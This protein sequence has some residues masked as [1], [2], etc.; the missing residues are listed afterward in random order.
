MPKTKNPF[1]S[2]DE[3]LIALDFYLKYGNKMPDQS[4]IEIQELSNWLNNLQK[5][6]GGDLPDKFRNINGVYMKLMNFRRI[7]PSYHGVGL[8]NG[9]KD[10]KVVWD[11][12]AANSG[13]LNKI[14]T[15]IKSI[16]KNEKNL[17]QLPVLLENE[18]EGNEG[19]V[20]SRVHRFRERNPKLIK[21]KKAEFKRKFGSLYCECCKFDFGKVY[22]SHGKDF[23]ECHHINPLSELQENGV[24]KLSDLAMLCSNCHRM[25]HKSRP[26]ISL[27]YLRKIL[28][29]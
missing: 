25:I 16:I 6:I 27:E 19:Q 12:F 26:W 13:E 23:I 4:S 2:R 3:H 7:D 17:I 11:L 15:Q 10:E 9:S 1:W 14:V 18:E 22:G 5:I 21:K 20:L 8:S 24:T 29:N 28:H